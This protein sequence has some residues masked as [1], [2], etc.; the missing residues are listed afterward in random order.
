MSGRNKTR[1]NL[2]LD[3]AIFLAF[4]LVLTPRATGVAI[5]EWLSIAF[6]ACIV[7]HLL[8]HWEWIIAVASKLF[9]RIFHESRLDFAVDLLLFLDVLLIMVSGLAIS[10]VA[11]PTLGIQI[12]FSVVWKQIHGISAKVA[13]VLAGIHCGLH[14]KWIGYN[15][16]KYLLEPFV[17]LFRRRTDGNA[18]SEVK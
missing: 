10:K 2:F 8:F 11:L 3:I 5:H 14:A 7:V 18:I 15:A 12:P 16:K 4:V 9:T 17:R 13:L 6:A 1:T